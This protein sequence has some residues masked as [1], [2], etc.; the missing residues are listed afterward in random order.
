[1]RGLVL[2]IL[3]TTLVVV[4]AAGSAAGF[5]AS[6]APTTPRMAR[7]MPEIETAIVTALQ[8]ANLTDRLIWIAADTNGHM[9][10][11]WLVLTYP[12]DLVDPVP[13][14]QERAWELVR[15]TFAAVPLLDEIHLT[16]LPRGPSPFGANRHL[17][18][19]SAAVSHAEF[20]AAERTS[21]G[22]PFSRFPRVWY[23]P[24]LLQPERTRGEDSPPQ[25]VLPTGHIAPERSG[26]FAGSREA[27]TRELSHQI[28]GLAY[29]MIVDGKFYHGDPSQ[30]AVALTFDDGP[31]PI[32]TSL[33]L[34]TLDRSHLKAT[35]F[36][37]GEDTEH[38]PYFAQAIVRAGHEI[39]NH[40]NHHPNLTRLS[41]QEVE[42]E[43]R[44]AQEVITS[45]TG[46]APRYFRPPGGDYDD[47][48]LRI[49][50]SLGL[51]TVFWTDNS[52]DYLNRG[53]RALEAKTLVNVTNGGIILFHQ[54]VGETIRIL[55][56]IAEALRQRGLTLTTVSGLL[57]TRRTPRAR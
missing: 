48:V 19:F 38:Y 21:S 4:V 26:A 13:L 49:A 28:A 9:T 53:P 2:G 45:V 51:V 35:L 15:T 1:M 10:I 29:G 41:V 5:Q 33:L 36:L 14:L 23:H 32:Y 8:A 25:P 55:P 42:D 56:Q 22:V 54:G 16:G 31:F 11:A 7:T 17:V 44:S 40:S 3:A 43:L 12:P 39:A 50:R 57:V 34:D 6:P 24:R 46:Q 30:R 37:V 18:T 27:R 47:T 52:G 20:L